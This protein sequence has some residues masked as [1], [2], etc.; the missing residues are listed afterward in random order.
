MRQGFACEILAAALRR[1]VHAKTEQ[2]CPARLWERFG[3][4]RHTIDHNCN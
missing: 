4:E 2:E 3:G 1:K